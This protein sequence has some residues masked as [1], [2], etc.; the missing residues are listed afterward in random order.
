MEELLQKY[1]L[2]KDYDYVDLIGLRILLLRKCEKIEASYKEEIDCPDC[3]E[4]L[5]QRSEML[6]MIAGRKKIWEGKLS[7]TKE[8]YRRIIS[9]DFDSPKITF[10]EMLSGRAYFKRKFGEISGR[11]S[12]R[13]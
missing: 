3:V 6:E 10:E 7:L 12:R 13:S 11:C 9:L 2:L 1:P 4:D 8:W 5:D